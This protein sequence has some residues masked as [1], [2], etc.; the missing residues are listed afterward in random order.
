M[1][2]F[3]VPAG[4]KHCLVSRVL[5]HDLALPPPLIYLLFRLCV[6]MISDSVFSAVFKT[7]LKQVK[8]KFRKICPWN[9]ERCKFH[10]QFPDTD[11]NVFL[12]WGITSLNSKIFCFFLLYVNLEL[13]RSERIVVLSLPRVCCGDEGWGC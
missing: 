8:W 11:R 9:P 13:A 7:C 6:Y 4:C 1:L 3:N 2:C 5:F 10:A 12:E